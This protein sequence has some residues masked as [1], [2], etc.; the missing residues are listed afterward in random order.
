MYLISI[1][2]H[3][4]LQ[5]F[6]ISIKKHLGASAFHT[7]EKDAEASP[8]GVAIHGCRVINIEINWCTAW[9]IVR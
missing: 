5:G 7:R 4:V 9:T 6:L 1:K 2:I 8:I 3:I